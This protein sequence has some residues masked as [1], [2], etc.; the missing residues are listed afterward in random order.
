MFLVLRSNIDV[1][2]V[3][4]G[5]LYPVRGCERL[6]VLSL[7][8]EQSRGARGRDL[9]PA[10]LIEEPHEL[11]FALAHH[12]L[13]H[14]LNQNCLTRPQDS[15]VLCL[16]FVLLC[17]HESAHA[18]RNGRRPASARPFG[19]RPASMLDSQRQIACRSQLPR[20]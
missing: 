17:S 18:P 15:I 10:E 16:H 13:A 12:L 3:E 1:V 5:H 2:G 19:G 6:L 8:L 4:L 11:V 9:A 7:T 14:A 20:C